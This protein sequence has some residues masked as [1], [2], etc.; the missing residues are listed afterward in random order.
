[1]ERIFIDREHCIAYAVL[2]LDSIY[3]SANKERTIN[4]FIQEIRT[5]FIV[6]KDE[7]HLMKIMKRIVNEKQKLIISVGKKQ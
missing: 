7:E 3:H 2:A 4:D 5:M 6:H 1:M